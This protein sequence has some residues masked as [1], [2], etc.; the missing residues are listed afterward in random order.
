MIE[1]A[2]RKIL[3]GLVEEQYTFLGWLQNIVHTMLGGTA[4]VRYLMSWDL[5]FTPSSG[6]D[7]PLGRTRPTS[8]KRDS[9]GPYPKRKISTRLNSKSSYAGAAPI[10]PMHLLFTDTNHAGVRLVTGHAIASFHT[11]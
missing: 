2:D 3:V 9:Q 8:S 11:P 5:H 1:L 10:L 4:R 7:C 6:C